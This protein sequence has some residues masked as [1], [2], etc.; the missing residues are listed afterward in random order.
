MCGRDCD[1]TRRKSAK[2]QL[3]EISKVVQEKLELKDIVS[4]IGEHTNACFSLDGKRVVSPIC[5]RK[6]RVDEDHDCL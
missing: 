4:Q 3:E 6:G 5:G 2:Q 1:R